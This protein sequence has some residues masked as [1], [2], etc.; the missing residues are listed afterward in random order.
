MCKNC[1]F[2]EVIFNE[3]EEALGFGCCIALPP[4]VITF[5]DKVQSVY[6]QVSKNR[7]PCVLFDKK[8]EVGEI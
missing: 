6:P 7:I 3:I 8:G 5:M 1:R 4:S 2:Y